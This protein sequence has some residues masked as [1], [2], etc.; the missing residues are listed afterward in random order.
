MHEEAFDERECKVD[1]D[2]ARNE[3]RDIYTYKL[4]LLGA[5]ESGKSTILKQIKLI[6]RWKPSKDDMARYAA[7]LR[8][9]IVECMQNVCEQAK[10][11]YGES[12]EVKDASA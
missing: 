2:L 3:V 4:L 8:T 10:V 9:N 1:I 5:G 6:N 12:I 11:F 7:G